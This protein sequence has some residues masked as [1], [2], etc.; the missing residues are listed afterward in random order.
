MAKLGIYLAYDNAK[1]A[2]EYYEKYFNAKI[3]QRLA[4]TKEMNEYFKL[5]ESK[6]SDS[7]YSGI[8]EIDG[9][10]IGCSDRVDNNENFN[11]SFNVMIEYSSDELHLYEAM[12]LRLNDCEGT[13]I[14]DSSEDDNVTYKMFRFVDKYNVIFSFTLM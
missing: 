13:I 12:V 1:E 4:I 10:V 11:D 5:D 14:Y 6:L 3:V 2:M 9:A 7:T 8:F